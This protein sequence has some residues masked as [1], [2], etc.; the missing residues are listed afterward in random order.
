VY[1]LNDG[2]AGQTLAKLPVNVA[3][4]AV[5]ELKGVHAAAPLLLDD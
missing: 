4:D 2:D 3:R 5:A 1:D